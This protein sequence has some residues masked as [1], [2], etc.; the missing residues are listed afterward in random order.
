MLLVVRRRRAAHQGGAHGGPVVLGQ[1]HNGRGFRYP[2]PI[3]ACFIGSLSERLV[4]PSGTP[5]VFDIKF[6]M[7]CKVRSW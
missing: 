2:V 3:A 1:R 7:S 5:Q 6:N 4:S